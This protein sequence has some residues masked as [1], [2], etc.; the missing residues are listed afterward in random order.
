MTEFQAITLRQIADLQKV[1]LDRG[2]P[3]AG[4]KPAAEVHLLAEDSLAR[5]NCYWTIGVM[6]RII[7]LQQRVLNS[8]VNDCPEQTATGPV[9]PAKEVLRLAK[10]SL[11]LK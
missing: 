10:A 11:G 7:G 6:T 8:G 2:V 1:V 3:D 4:Q 5:P 9:Q